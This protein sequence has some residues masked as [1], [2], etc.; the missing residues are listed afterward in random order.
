MVKSFN[1]Q[2][3]LATLRKSVGDLSLFGPKAPAKGSFQRMAANIYIYT[4]TYIFIVIFW[5]LL[6][7]FL[8]FTIIF[9]DL[10]Y[11]LSF[12]IFII[13]YLFR[14]FELF[15]DLSDLSDNNNNNHHQRDPLHHLHHYHHKHHA[16]PF[17]HRYFRYSL[18]NVYITLKNHHF[19]WVNQLFY[20]HFQ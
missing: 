10:Y 4:Y 14:S 18:V 5:S 15:S 2:W 1:S 19:Q 17:Y 6:S 16:I 11:I 12:L 13:Y 7:F 3:I 20:G 9:S 8:I